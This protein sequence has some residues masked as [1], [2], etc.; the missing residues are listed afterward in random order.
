MDLGRI[1]VR[2]RERACVIGGV[3]TGKSTLIEALIVDYWQRYERQHGR[4]LILDSKP[5]FKAEYEPDGWRTKR[6]YRH[7]DHGAF[8]PGSVLVTNPTDME[9]AWDTGHR[10]VIAQATNIRDIPALVQ[11]T[12]LFFEQSRARR[13]QLLVVDETSDFFHTN[14]ARMGGTDSLLRTARAGRERG[15][16]GIFGMQRTK[17]VPPQ[18]LEEM[19]RLYLFRVDYTTDVNRLTEM[20]APRTVVRDMPRVKHRFMYWTKDEYSKLYGPYTLTL[21]KKG[22]A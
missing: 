10:I 8:V 14:T 7:W 5:R 22:V 15:L 2:Q 11:C 20:G 19:T 21:P 12:E 3:G 9:S 4:I 17:G 6:R 1:A 18:L 16:G 13:P